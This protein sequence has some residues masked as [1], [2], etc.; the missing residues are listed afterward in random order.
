MLRITFRHISGSRATQLDVIQLGAHR[1]LI[2]GRALSAAVRFDPRDD[3]AVGRQHARITPSANEPGRLMLTDLGSRNGT[4]L[5][6]QRVGTTV[7]L[8]SGDVVQL[9]EM[10]PE[11]EILIEETT[12]VFV[13]E[14]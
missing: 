10:G 1:E 4:L 13:R 7:S 8:Q 14:P 12:L 9:G 2:L 6:G 5:N 3:T 11:L